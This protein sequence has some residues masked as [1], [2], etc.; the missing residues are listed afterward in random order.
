VN[1]LAVV[2]G[3]L[4]KKTAQEHLDILTIRMMRC[5]AEGNWQSQ[6]HWGGLKSTRRMAYFKQNILMEKILAKYPS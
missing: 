1:N 4:R 5:Y 2:V 6:D 3:M